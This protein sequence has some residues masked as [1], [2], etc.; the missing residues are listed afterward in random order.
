MVWVL[1]D[2]FTSSNSLKHEVSFSFVF[3]LIHDEYRYSQ[4]ATRKKNVLLTPKKVRYRTENI[5]SHTNLTK[6]GVSYEK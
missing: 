6:C 3:S 4:R 2:T 5:F 1:L